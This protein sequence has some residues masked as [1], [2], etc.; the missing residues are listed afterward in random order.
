MRTNPYRYKGGGYWRDDSVA[1]GTRAN[2]LHGDEALELGRWS[3]V[4]DCQEM[5]EARAAALQALK[6]V[7]PGGLMSPGVLAAVRA[8]IALLEGPV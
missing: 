5:I 4:E 7:E 6:A 1:Y 2:I 3:M 8:A